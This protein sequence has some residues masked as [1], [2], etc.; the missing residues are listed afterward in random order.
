MR[1]RDVE[2]I[3]EKKEYEMPINADLNQSS[4]HVIEEEKV[5]LVK[6]LK[7][8][9]DLIF[10]YFGKYYND[11]SN[12]TDTFSYSKYSKIMSS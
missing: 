9:V 5:F 2:I 11:P 7:K 1:R 12:H 6:G 4:S 8:D 10:T 3:E